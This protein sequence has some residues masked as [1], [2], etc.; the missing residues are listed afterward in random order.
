MRERTGQKTEGMCRHYKPEEFG[1][2]GGQPDTVYC[3]PREETKKGVG[4]MKV[5]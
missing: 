4:E 5:E 3:H 1:V 2:S